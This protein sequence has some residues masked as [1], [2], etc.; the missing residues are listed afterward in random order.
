MSTSAICLFGLIAWTI[1]LAIGLISA[2]LPSIMGGTFLF[3]QDGTDLAGFGQRITRAQGNSLEWLV[4][5]AALILYGIA[6]GQGAVTDGLAMI[7]L[8][9]RLGQSIVHIASVSFPAVL[10]RATLFTAQIV[11][12]VMWTWGFY[13]AAG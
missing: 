4:I 6:T 12:W 5:P 1:F 9:A 8:Y 10:V 2:R 13:S 11:I 3:T 7:V